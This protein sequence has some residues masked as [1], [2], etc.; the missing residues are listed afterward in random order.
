MLETVLII[1]FQHAAEWKWEVNQYEMII[2]C[3]GTLIL[4]LGPN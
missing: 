3:T 2:L 1:G 4:Y